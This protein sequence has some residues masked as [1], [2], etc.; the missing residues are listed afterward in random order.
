MKQKT[1][2]QKT[3]KMKPNKDWKH[4]IK[5][6]INL[7]NVFCEAKVICNKNGVKIFTKL[8]I[9]QDIKILL[10]NYQG[11]NQWLE[12]KIVLFTVLNFF[13]M[14]LQLKQFCTNIYI[15]KILTII[16]KQIL[17]YYHHHYNIQTNTKYTIKVIF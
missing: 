8:L 16:K 17:Q 6:L 7:K 4:P 13:R 1:V 10:H 14:I 12:I 9:E 3:K 15:D 2:Y 11:Q 5:K